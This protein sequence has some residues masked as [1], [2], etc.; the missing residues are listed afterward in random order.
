MRSTY[1]TLL[2]AST[3]AFAAERTP[4]APHAPAAIGEQ[5]VAAWSFDPGTE[6]W[7]ALNQAVAS[8]TNG[9]LHITATG[10]DPYLR[11]PLPPTEGPLLLSG[12]IRTKVRGPMEWYWA[13]A[14]RPDMSPERTLRTTVKTDGQWHPFSAVIDVREPMRVLRIDPVQAEGEVELDDIQVKRQILHPVQF[15]SLETASDGA[16]FVL[17]N[18]TAG[19]LTASAG[20]T[21]VEVPAGGTA[22]MHV[23]FAATEAMA[24]ERLQVGIDGK[25]ALERSLFIDRPDRPLAG[26]SIA[27]GAW[28]AT[29]KPDGLGVRLAHDGRPVASL[30]PLAEK[31]GRPLPLV[32]TAT[33]GVLR[34]SGGP[35]RAGSLRF[36]A[37]DLRIEIESDEEITGPSLRIP[38]IIEEALLA[39]VEYLGRGEISSSTLDIER[40]EH[41]RYEPDP[42]LVTMPL[43]L[44]ATERG[45]AAMLWDDP[46]LRPSFS[47]PN[48]YDG[49]A[50]QRVA[51]RGKSIRARIRLVPSADPVEDAVAWAVA[52]RGLPEP[53]VPPRD[54]A[55]QRAL[56]RA[57]YEG[58]LR[59]T[60]GW[61][62]VTW[63]G[64][65]PYFFSDHA[66]AIFRLDGRPPEVPRM[67]WGGA[68]VLNP[69]S[70]LV[71]GR[72]EEWLRGLAGSAQTSIEQQRPDG[73]FRYDGPYRRG[74]FEDTASGHCAV[75][76]LPMLFHAWYTGNTNSLAAGLRTLDY[77]KRFK[78]PRGAQVW[79]MPIHTPDLQAV[80]LA[81]RAYV[82]GYRLTGRAEYLDLARRWALRGIP[83]IYQWDG[84]PIMR[85][86]SIAVL[87]AT[88]WHGVVWIGLPV[89]WAGTVYAYSLNEL[90]EFDTSLD[91][92]KIARGV[93]I[94]AEQMQHPDGPF[95]GCLP[96]SFNLVEQVRLPAPVNPCVLVSLREQ[97]AGRHDGVSVLV[98]DGH[99][100]AA[101]FPLKREGDRVAI[102]GRAGL[103]YQVVVD[104]RRV[105]E[106]ESKGRDEVL[107]PALSGP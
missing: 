75:M 98:V 19:A 47:V 39:G 66:S 84:A 79:E 59:T 85:Y 9:V 62:H 26:P 41:I 10:P 81:V 90:A 69:A 92:R 80:S 88:D 31:D 77:M 4:L 104:G 74:H 22:T 42:M 76:A 52:R 1:A 51:L 21:R 105:I 27:S 82:L 7:P 56:L 58:S 99:R 18:T 14:S 50:D 32:V 86:A 61:F 35:V 95:A 38:G 72:G 37:G 17:T 12:R 5:V 64:Q 43:A 100:I 8:V 11:V 93:T 54:E 73:S 23:G 53:P 63:D 3:A 60:N 40:S 97:M 29:A 49:T 15:Q 45:S 55:A 83:F 96:D 30:L 87:G 2:L 24:W 33:D 94:C 16:T 67:E 89:Q 107:L 101:P 68:H 71:T 20:G 44:L 102:E 25:P 91:W 13:S 106:I 57:A 34:F 6:P 78:T 46:M 65:K 28:T 103:R 70:Y 48:R 36:D